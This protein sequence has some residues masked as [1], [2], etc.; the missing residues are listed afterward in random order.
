MNLAFAGFRHSH[1]LGLYDMAVNSDKVNITGCFEENSEAREKAK[2]DKGIVFNYES[3]EEL[4]SDEKVDAVAIGDYYGIRGKMVIEA[5][6]SGKHVICDKPICTSLSELEEIERLTKEKNLKLAC[7]F[8]LRYIPQIAKVKEI[9][10]E[11]GIGGLI[12]ISFT[13][14]H[15]LD[16]GNRPGWYFEEGKHGGTVNDIAIHGIDL[17]KFITGKSLSNINCVKTWNAFADKEP[18][19]KDCAQFMVEMEGISVMADVSYAAPK[20]NKFLPT[21]WDFYFWGKDGMI[22]FKYCESSVHLYRS[23]CEEIIECKAPEKTYID[24]FIEEI[25]GEGIGTDTVETLKSQRQVLE[26]QKKA[27][28]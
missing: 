24:E 10:K 3:Y 2:A 19:F 20:C 7:M 27:D 21:Y 28:E 14:Q 5:L 17:I 4:L 18:D 13:G 1:I 23:G 15:F 11:G 26:I 25:N 22:N 16:Y 6:K 9:V 12:N 8:D